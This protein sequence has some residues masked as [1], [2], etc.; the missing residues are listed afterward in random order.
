MLIMNFKL[1]LFVLSTLVCVDVFADEHCEGIEVKKG[2]VVEIS[3]EG[4][5]F[6]L[7]SLTN[8]SRHECTRS[9]C[10]TDKC[11]L[12]VFNTSTKVCTLVHCIDCP[13]FES[14]HSILTYIG[15]DNQTENNTLAEDIAASQSNQTQLLNETFQEESHPVNEN[16]IDTET[17]STPS[18]SETLPKDENNTLEETSSYNE[19]GSVRNYINSTLIETPDTDVHSVNDTLDNVVENSAGKND[20]SIELSKPVTPLVNTSVTSTTGKQGTSVTTTNQPSSS[21]QTEQVESRTASY[22]TVTETSNDSNS[23]DGAPGTKAMQPEKDATTETLTSPSISTTTTPWR[24]LFSFLSTVY[25][26]TSKSESQA[27]TK[28]TV[29]TQNPDAELPSSQSTV[30]LPPTS[31][32]SSSSSLSQSDLWTYGSS[33]SEEVSTSSILSTASS[34]IFSTSSSFS[35]HYESTTEAAASK[36]DD[37]ADGS[38]NSQHGET[39]GRMKGPKQ[40]STSLVVALSIGVFFTFVLLVVICKRLFE[41][42]Q[43]RHYNKLDYLINGM[44]N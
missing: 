12:T 42:W 33:P 41:G 8:S 28:A 7:S 3:P 19:T 39:P 38:T 6:N 32:M 37:Q 25:T 34:S 4:E 44:Y 10:N 17:V 15:S 40:L 18:V 31:T 24:S 2:F 9:C 16:V 22:T 43:R 11:T 23:T 21:T 5:S 1:I 35:F 30:N 13:V 27:V 29:S 36:A 26:S 14:E 20:E